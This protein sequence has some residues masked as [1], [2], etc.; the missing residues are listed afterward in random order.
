RKKDMIV[1]SGF[2]V[3]PNEIESV[4]LE[5]A[6]VLECVAIG[7][8]SA[9]RGEEPKIFVVRKHNRVTAEQLLAFGKQ[10]LSGYKRP[11]YVEFVDS[12][13][14]SNVGKILR[15]ELRKREGLE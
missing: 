15:K 14:K 1:V 2:N 9:T 6:D 4:M 8:P 7:V 3:Y 11:R 13:P 12:L 5:H 10:H